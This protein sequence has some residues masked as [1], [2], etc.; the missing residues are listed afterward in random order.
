[1]RFY[2]A[3]VVG[4]R[5]EGREKYVKR[6][7]SIGDNLRFVPE[8]DNPHSTNGDAIA[9]YHGQ[10]KVGYLPS[11]K[12][13]IRESI[14]EGDRH[15][16]TITQFVYNDEGQLAVLAIEVGVEDN[17][18]EPPPPSVGRIALEALRDELTVLVYIAKSDSRLVLAERELI[19]RYAQAR[20]E[21]KS[22]IFNPEV[23]GYLER[24]IKKQTPTDSNMR[25][26]IYRLEINDVSAIDA[27]VE[28]T[29][30]VS[31]VGQGKSSEYSAHLAAAQEILLQSRAQI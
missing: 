14:A 8:P 21:D 2:P 30:L 24:W 7:V 4:V 26:S 22:I 3:K 13:W 31:E 11:E 9:V 5:Y 23:Y 28:V 16:I 19:L 18:P 29:V 17:N 25:T 15:E 20:C 6:H 10:F 1:M 27:L 12:R